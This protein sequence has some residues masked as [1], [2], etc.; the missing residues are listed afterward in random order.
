MNEMA[1]WFPTYIQNA[2]TSLIDT[3]AVFDL[4]SR[5]M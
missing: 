4:G 3:H 1:K 2:F 5:A